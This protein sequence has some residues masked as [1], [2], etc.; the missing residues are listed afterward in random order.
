MGNLA[1]LKRRTNAAF[2][3]KTMNMRIPF[4]VAT[5]GM[6][7]TDNPGNKGLGFIDIEKHAENDTADGRK[8]AIQKSPVFKEIVSEFFGNGKDTMPVS[9]VNEFRSHGSRAFNGI[10][11]AAGR[12]E[13][14]VAAKRAKLKKAATRTGI[15]GT[16]KGRIAAA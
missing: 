12:A 13:A 3:D 5:E 1:P 9:T 10:L 4:Q 14:A 8:E 11:V 2:G 7:N 6:K 16:A 15:H